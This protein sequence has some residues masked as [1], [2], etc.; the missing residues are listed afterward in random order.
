MAFET[1]V[2][3]RSA[4]SS[5]EARMTP[6]ATHPGER[7][8]VVVI[9]AG[10]GGLATVRGLRNQPVR[11][12]WIDRKNYHLF[13]PLL[14]QVATAALSPADIAAPTRAVAR[15]WRN[16]EA[17]L[18]EVTAIDVEAR[19]VETAR[20]TYAYDYLVVA[21]GAETSYFGNERWA[22]FAEG[23]KTL[24][25][26]VAIRRKVLLALELA[27]TEQ[28]EEER[29][30][31]LTFI[32]IGAGPTG[33]EMAG[34][35]ADLAKHMLARD[36]RHIRSHAISVI[37]LEAA[38]QVLPGYP[39]DLA[40]FAERKLEEMGVDVRTGTRVEDIDEEGV[41][42]G[43]TRI[44]GRT[45]I[46]G[47]GVKA[48][49]VASSLGTEADRKGLV[50]VR[51]DL[52][53]PGRPE[54]FVIGDAALV[55]DEEGRPLPGLAAVAK[56]QGAFVA[57]RILDRIEDREP[58]PAFRYRDWGTLA[59]MGKAS[60]VADFG[61]LRLRGFAAWMVWVLV[62]IW[63]LIGFRNRLQVLINWVWLYATFSSGARI[64]TGDTRRA[65]LAARR[66]SSEAG[67]R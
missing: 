7:P 22:Q 23:L 65:E 37:L 42:A 45:I 44:A 2:A 55:L 59:T 1:Q 20:Q 17:V 56:Q 50:K 64:I 14:Y 41:F 54:V 15:N 12:T 66:E 13:Q 24:E 38:D 43:G 46:W 28:S 53:L 51:P 31:L 39:R 63:Y 49:P 5:K 36:F 62:H 10:F 34:A 30:R 16:V 19:I 58:A 52:S 11:V 4:W 67:A 26:A 32:L 60:A 40:T 27:E 3:A 47:A 18:G 8:H 35:I 57:R 6:R 48:T 9:G 25:E 29:R 33:V 21:T 61:R